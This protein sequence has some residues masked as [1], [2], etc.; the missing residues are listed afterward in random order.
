MGESKRSGL[1]SA[2]K[3]GVKQFNTTIQEGG[4]LQHT[5]RQGVTTLQSPADTLKINLAIKSGSAV[6]SDYEALSRETTTYSKQL[7]LW[8]QESHGNDLKDVSDRLAWI[9][10]E[11]AKLYKA[12]AQRID[13]AR[14]ALKDVRNYENDLV[15]KRKNRAAL[16][17]KLATTKSSS[18][19][20]RMTAEIE[21][22]DKELAPADQMLESLKRTKLHES[23]SLQL[24]AQRELGEKLSILAGYGELLLRTLESD[25]FGSEY[26]GQEKTA[27]IKG[28][29]TEALQAWSAANAHIPTPTLR[30][31]GDSYLGRAD[32]QSFASTQGSEFSHVG[33]SHSS[34]G[35]MHHSSSSHGASPPPSISGGHHLTPIPISGAA[36]AS[37]PSAPPIPA[38]HPSHEG[39]GAPAQIYGSS[40]GG[41]INL[42]PTPHD[43]GPSYSPRQQAYPVEPVESTPPSMPAGP[44]VAET[45]APIVGTGGPIS[46]QLPNRKA[47]LS[48]PSGGTVLSTI[49][50]HQSAAQEKAL[51]EQAQVERERTQLAGS[52]GLGNSGPIASG[53]GMSTQHPPPDDL[54]PSYTDGLP[55]DGTDARARAEAEQILAAE[56][57]RKQAP[58]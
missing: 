46:G 58:L 7:F 10:F 20:K 19:L 22:I 56:R 26:S 21:Q 45:G 28:Q 24:Q 6:V 4:S 42:S 47:S 49:A 23:F 55:R 50:Q 12:H 40:P 53:S 38:R 39:S 48:S 3:D 30:E 11:T 1:F 5:L 54:P 27:R 16:Q 34:H 15:P 2:L 32:T 52:A 51:L 29:A 13:Q 31:G 43:L 9:E 18:D 36:V 37:R 25:G 57:E 14:S 8:G 33:D 44:T 41:H 35:L 17:A